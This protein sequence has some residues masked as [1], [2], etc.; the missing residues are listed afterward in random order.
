MGVIFIN[1]KSVYDHKSISSKSN[2]N[3]SH[4]M[5]AEIKDDNFSFYH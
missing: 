5:N 2:D 4:I 1:R 3:N